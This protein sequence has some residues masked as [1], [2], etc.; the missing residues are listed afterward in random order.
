MRILHLTSHLHLGGITRY[1]LTLSQLQA[2]QGHQVLVASDRGQLEPQLAPWGVTHWR[3]PLNTSA[4]F[5]PRVLR[6][7]GE[8][9]RRLRQ[10][11]VDVIHAHTRVGQVVAD[12]ISCRLGIP[13]VTTW[14]GNYKPRLG[15][16]LWPC[17]GHRTIAISG[18]VREHLRQQF[19]VPEERIRRIHNG[20]D[21]VHY[22]TSPEPSAI[23]A[24]RAQWKIP[25]GCPIMGGIGRLAAGEV[26]GFDMLLA[27]TCLLKSVVPGLQTIVVGDGPRRPFLEDVARRLK[28][29]DRVHF[30]GFAQDIR[31]PLALMNVFV[32]PSRWPEAFGLTLV[33]AMAAGTP[34]VAT[35]IGAIPE[36][37]QHGVHGWLFPPDDLAS[38]TQGIAT[39][40]RDSATA[41]KFGTQAQARVREA[42][43]LK[44][45]AA[46]VE[47]VYREVTP[48]S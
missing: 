9:T 2:A 24:Y 34:V 4:E 13:Y 32:F 46:Q 22:T 45:M 17:T 5:S 19:H 31:V 47:A 10:E 29:R 37:V 27:A 25:E 21:S 39:L 18:P 44:R 23:Q 14:H 48:A 42:F 11:P 8:L 41:K 12:R 20:I 6:A 28:I 38:M 16:R 15:R 35:Q 3:V 36:I 40:L 43:S 30:V 1:V 33:E 7:S 26:K